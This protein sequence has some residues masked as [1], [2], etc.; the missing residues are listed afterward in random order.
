MNGAISF[1]ITTLNTKRKISSSANNIDIHKERKE[2]KRNILLFIN[3]LP[4]H[5]SLFVKHARAKNSLQYCKMYSYHII[6]QNNPYFKYKIYLKQDYVL[7]FLFLWKNA[8]SR[9]FL[10]LCSFFFFDIFIK[11]VNV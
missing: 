6:T 7:S 9:M 2:N 3:T 5:I 1:I 4:N 11:F 8:V 10:C